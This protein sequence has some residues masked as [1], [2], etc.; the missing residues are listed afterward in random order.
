MINTKKKN[1][2][3]KSK[4]KSKIKNNTPYRKIE[5]S[6][7]KR[8]TNLIKTKKNIFDFQGGDSK[9]TYLSIDGT[10][11]KLVYMDLTLLSAWL[12]MSACRGPAFCTSGMPVQRLPGASTRRIVVLSA[13]SMCPMKW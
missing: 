11:M 10:K 7:V 3:S 12:A 4:I 9:H 2:I 6:R 8:K 13:L 5:K 1:Q